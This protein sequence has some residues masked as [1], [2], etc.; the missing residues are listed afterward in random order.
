MCKDKA[1]EPPKWEPEDIIELCGLL[2]K[3]EQKPG[4]KGASGVSA[5]L[6]STRLILEG[7]KVPRS[8]WAMVAT[9]QVLPDVHYAYILWAEIDE[10]KRYTWD[11][12]EDFMLY[13]FLGTASK[14]D[15]MICV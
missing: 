2:H 11:G 13:Y 9:M 10:E 1:P 6:S 7:Y 4:R 3:F 12:F 5:W 14:F 15:A 8:Q